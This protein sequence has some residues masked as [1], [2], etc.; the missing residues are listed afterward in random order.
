[1]ADPEGFSLDEAASILAKKYGGGAPAS[2]P[3]PVARQEPAGLEQAGP[4]ARGAAVLPP[5]GISIE[6][7][8]ALLAKKD[9]PK[10]DE[11]QN[12]GVN[13]ANGVYREI[14]HVLGMTTQLNPISAVSGLLKLLP[15]DVRK[16]VENENP[17]TASVIKNLD[18]MATLIGKTP[19]YVLENLGAINKNVKQNTMGD[20]I[21]H[22]AGG[23]TAAMA[24][25]GLGAEAALAQTWRESGTLMKS[26]SDILPSVDATAPWL[27]EMLRGSGFFS[28]AAMGA[29][30]GATGEVVGHKAEEMAPEGY[31]KYAR[32]I[33]EMVGNVAGGLPVAVSAASLD[34]MF[35][36]IGD[37]LRANYSTASK[38]MRGAEDPE[39]ARTALANYQDRIPGSEAT[40]GQATGDKGILSQEKRVAGT[41]GSQ[42]AFRTRMEEQNTART[43]AIARLE[44]PG[45]DPAMFK[46]YLK[47]RLGDLEEE[48]VGKVGQAARDAAEALEGAGGGRFADP[49]GYGKDV[50]G[51]LEAV[52]READ[53]K[54]DRMLEAIDP[55]KRVPVNTDDLKKGIADVYNG[56]PK[57]A[58]PPAGEENRLLS[59]VEEYGPSETFGEIVELRRSLVDEIR[60]ERAKSAAVSPAERRMTEAVRVIDDALSTKAADVVAEPEGRA[61]LLAE[62]KREAEDHVAANE[63][64]SSAA[65]AEASG[66]TPAGGGAGAGGPGAGAPG[67]RPGEVPPAPGAEGSAAGGPGLASGGQGVS[68]EQLQTKLT[69]LRAQEEAIVQKWRDA[70]DSGNTEEMK[71]LDRLMEKAADWADEAEMN[72]ADFDHRATGSGSYDSKTG[73]LEGPSR[74]APGG[75][76]ISREG[77]AGEAP[78]A[79]NEPSGPSGRTEV[80]E[81]MNPETDLPMFVYENPSLDHIR[82]IAEQ[83][84]DGIVHV[85][86]DPNTGKS[87]A[88]HGNEMD[89]TDIP[90]SIGMGKG[91]RLTEVIMSNGEP[92]PYGPNTRTTGPYYLKNEAHSIEDSPGT[93][94]KNIEDFLTGENKTALE[95]LPGDPDEAAVVAAKASREAKKK[96]NPDLAAQ[97]DATKARGEAAMKKFEEAYDRG[98]KAG[99]AAANK[100]TDAAYAEHNRLIDQL[101]AIPGPVAKG[102]TADEIATELKTAKEQHKASGRE[103]DLDRVI[104]LTNEHRAAKKT[105]DAATAA[106]VAEETA[107]ARAGSEERHREAVGAEAEKRK[108]YE[109]GQ[110]GEVLR[111]GATEGTFRTPASV[112]PGRLFDSPEGLASF[113]DAAKGDPALRATAADHAAFSMKSAAVKDGVLSP[114]RLRDWVASHEYVLREFPELR[115]KFR[116]AAAAQEALDEALVNQKKALEDFSDKA[117]Q[118]VLGTERTT[119]V[120]GSALARP[121]DME[122]LAAKT[123]GDEIARAG[124]RRGA[125]DHIVERATKA[126]ESGTSGENIIDGS[127]IEGLVKRYEESLGKIFSPEEIQSMRDVVA[128]FQQ[129]QRTADAVKGSNLVGRK[130]SNLALFMVRR[131]GEVVGA[132]V[133]AAAGHHAG[134]I[135]HVIGG[136]AAGLAA[137]GAADLAILRR[138]GGSEKALAEMLLDRD[139]AR[140]W[141]NRVHVT[142]SNRDTWASGL[143]RRIRALELGAL[144]NAAED[145][146]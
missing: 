83:A 71:R 25:P 129:A 36:S 70:K 48:H 120:I 106:R 45:A 80:I 109:E 2:A 113:V 90:G 97:I 79:S 21:A 100:E 146:Q 66:G 132:A 82:K 62:L 123:A 131:M 118:R 127:V 68:R 105:E 77:T 110:V 11:S 10:K 99:V 14:G 138:M 101:N 104:S 133:G 116:D 51:K 4:E 125:I 59:V 142:E 43:A 117:T 89:D 143:A 46:D 103:E 76:R 3:S 74:V 55:D 91:T 111:P 58:R 29:A 108:T 44:D 8:T 15:D 65:V 26:L 115:S 23:A 22:A 112:V 49:A 19:E 95:V 12:L 140:F 35:Q 54:V 73:S 24:V 32:M 37:K 88:W 6:D 96:A 134:G 53:A 102:T 85:A 141:T 27:T 139:R 135:G 47:T 94:S 20:K 64:A 119:D 28:N 128:D 52:H 78:V 17:H 40:V 121:G 69:S 60:K 145:S 7:A 137:G 9:E 93:H 5:A 130:M 75:T 34:R 30:G 67:V 92:Q 84:D 72:L 114:Q 122:S 38:M 33:G 124:L 39:A 1:M 31:K 107:R 81:I 16:S 50:Q 86:H 18:R 42:A 98:D 63:N 144:G 126:K 136:A 61:R 41:E 13:F 56:A 87:Y 57:A